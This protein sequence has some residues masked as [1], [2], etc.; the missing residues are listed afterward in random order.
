LRE[1]VPAKQ[2]QSSE[3]YD[4]PPV[5]RFTPIAASDNSPPSIVITLPLM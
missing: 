4:G 2:H 1:A 3:T 5:I